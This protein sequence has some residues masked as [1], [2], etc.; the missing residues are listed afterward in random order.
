MNV[1]QTTSLL[2]NDATHW[3]L[4]RPLRVGVVPLGAPLMYDCA[5][6]GN[7]NG[8]RTP[9]VRALALP[10]RLWKNADWS[11]SES[12]SA[13]AYLCTICVCE[14]T[15]VCPAWLCECNAVRCNSYLF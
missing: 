6:C 9:I 13:I 7:I 2:Y 4:S 15:A 3:Q 14:V 5:K 8:D 10:P 11:D 12:L 1:T